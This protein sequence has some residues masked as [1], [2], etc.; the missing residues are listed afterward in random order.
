VTD[1]CKLY[2]LF[3]GLARRDGIVYFVL[4]MFCLFPGKIFDAG[5]RAWP[6][7]PRIKELKKPLAEGTS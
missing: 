2:L 7:S 3:T 4:A 1:P 5:P 6:Q